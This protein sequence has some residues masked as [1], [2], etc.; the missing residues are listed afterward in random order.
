[1]IEPL[2]ILKAVMYSSALQYLTVQL[3]HGAVQY[4]VEISIDNIIYPY[5]VVSAIGITHQ[6]HNSYQV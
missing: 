4:F 6:H 2:R 3:L 1:M 5:A